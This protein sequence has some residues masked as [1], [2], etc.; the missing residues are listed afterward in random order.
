MLQQ[1]RKQE[2]QK[3]QQGFLTIGHGRHLA[4]RKA[5][6]RCTSSIH[7]STEICQKSAHR[8]TAFAMEEIY[9]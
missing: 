3:L 2:I 6:K 9:L 1:Q 7:P 5:G 4:E 8:G